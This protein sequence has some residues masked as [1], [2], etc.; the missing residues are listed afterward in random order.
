[1]VKTPICKCLKYWSFYATVGF[2]T[3]AAA[4]PTGAI[5]PDMPGELLLC[6]AILTQLIRDAH[7][8]NKDRRE[9]AWRFVHNPKA[10]GYWADMLGLDAEWLRDALLRAMRR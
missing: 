3:A 9:Q 1:L 7:G 10:V 5:D 4:N 8:A 6:G 2:D